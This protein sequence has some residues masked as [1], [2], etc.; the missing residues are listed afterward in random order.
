MYSKQKT[1][2]VSSPCVSNRFGFGPDG[3]SISFFSSFF[4]V[5]AEL[6]TDLSKL[7]SMLGSVE[8]GG[9]GGCCAGGAYFFRF[10]LL[11]QMDG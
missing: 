10:L 2:D 3:F 4:G 8:L 9:A 5:L 1:F 7:K 6:T 11:N